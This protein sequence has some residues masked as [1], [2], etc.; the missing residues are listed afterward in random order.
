MYC[1]KVDRN[2]VFCSDPIQIKLVLSDGREIQNA[3]LMWET[4]F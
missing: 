2:A 3:W 1:D 4:L